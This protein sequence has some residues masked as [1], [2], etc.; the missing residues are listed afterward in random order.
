MTLYG[1]SKNP[2]DF[3]KKRDVFSFDTIH[4]KQDKELSEN[5]KNLKE[6]IN[7]HRSHE[8]MSSGISN[9]LDIHN[10]QSGSKGNFILFSFKVIYVIIFKGTSSLICD[11]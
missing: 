9:T 3:I 10:K 8:E 11:S 7:N 1:T 4:R 2:D 6:S 5:H